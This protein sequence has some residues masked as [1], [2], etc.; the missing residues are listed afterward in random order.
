MVVAIIMLEEEDLIP[1]EE[2]D[3]ISLEEEDLIPLEEEDLIPLEEEDL[4][5]LEV[6]VA[7]RQVLH[8]VQVTDQLQMMMEMTMMMMME[9]TMMMMMKMTMMMEGLEEV[10]VPMMIVA[11]TA[12][13]SRRKLK[14]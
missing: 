8:L 1:L 6:V 11:R 2:E 13:N 5:P 10:A 14:K 4:I 9:M 7:Q 3:L 12:Q